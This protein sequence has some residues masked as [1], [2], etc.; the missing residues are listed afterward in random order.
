MV[1]GTAWGG[2]KKKITKSMKGIGKMI[3]DVGMALIYI[4]ME[5]FTMVD[6]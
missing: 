6:S 1:F 4:K 2:G 5:L 3:E